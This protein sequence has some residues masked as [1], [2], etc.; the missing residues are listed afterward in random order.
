MGSTFFG[1]NVALSGVLTQQRALNTVTHNI[2]NATTPGYT[3]Q[4]VDMQAATAYP[5]PALNTAVGAGQIGTG[6]VAIQH[7]RVRD[8]FADVTVRTQSSLTGEWDARTNALRSLDRIIDEPGD[9][10]ITA[11]LSRF[12]SSW[13]GLSSQPDSAASR[14]AVRASGALLAQGIH[15]LHASFTAQQTEADGRIGLETGRVNDLAGQIN[16][17]NQRIALVVATGQEPNDLRDLRD[18]LVDELAGYTSI[19]V[20]S[21]TSDKLSIAVGGQL[22]VDGS[23]DTVSPFAIDPL[24]NASVGGVPVTLGSG[25]LVGH[26]AI[27]DQVI[28]GA[29]GYL[30]QLDILAGA[31]ANS[32]NAVHSAGFGTDGSTGNDFFAGT[33]ASTIGVSAA[34]SASVN[35]IAASATATGLPSNADNAVALAQLQFL[36][37]PIGATPTNLDGFYQQFVTRLGTDVDQANRIAE[38]Q[39]GVLD[40]AHAR[41]DAVGGVNI[42]E[43]TADML[44]FSKSYNAAAR[45][46]TAVDEMLETIISRMGIVGR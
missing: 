19:T 2:T 15:D 33:T 44:R 24:G 1:L 6:V 20:T 18:N 46:V 13:Q 17:V 11:L 10:G 38:A 31:I 29:G 4:R 42:D 12:W 3:R 37:Q 27:R 9:T 25:S 45:M 7:T 34:V 28:G 43:E 14:E 8:Q 36:V 30:A 35:K 39:R 22:L 26:L 21:G 23:S 5:M 41:R 16:A 40:A 32:V